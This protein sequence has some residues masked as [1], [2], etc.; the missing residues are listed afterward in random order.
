MKFSIIKQADQPEGDPTAS[1]QWMLPLLTG[2]AGALV[3]GLATRRRRRESASDRARRVIANALGVGALGAVGGWAAGSGAKSIRDYI[4]DKKKSDGEPGF[5]SSRLARTGYA[6]A[7]RAAQL[8][9]TRGSYINRFRELAKIPTDNPL[10]FVPVNRAEGLAGAKDAF[11]ENISTIKSKLL[12]ARNK[13]DLMMQRDVY[14]LVGH[15]NNPGKARQAL[16]RL[17]VQDPASSLSRRGFN[18]SIHALERTAGMGARHVNDLSGWGRAAR[19]GRG[20]LGLATMAGAYLAPDAV[21]YFKNRSKA[22]EAPNWL[23]DYINPGIK[24]ETPEGPP[25]SWFEKHLLTGV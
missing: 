19:A 18:R 17:G 24:A 22:D 23:L 3:G 6:G 1:N 20:T 4:D 25:P 15:P 21:N 9:L 5:F 13:G 2:G 7:V 11:R 12:E 8:P 10:K 16:S 14:K